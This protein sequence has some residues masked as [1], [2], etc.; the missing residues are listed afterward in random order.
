M[1]R[2]S[3]VRLPDLYLWSGF[4]RI[5]I[6]LGATTFGLGKIDD[7]LSFMG[8]PTTNANITE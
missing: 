6:Q 5:I 7:P 3:A 4:D 1:R 8:F 2:G